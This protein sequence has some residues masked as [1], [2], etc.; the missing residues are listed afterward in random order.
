MLGRLRS[1]NQQQ[2]SGR[3]NTL[4]SYRMQG[5]HSP[6]VRGLRKE[7]AIRAGAQVQHVGRIQITAVPHATAVLPEAGG[8]SCR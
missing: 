8:R 1:S 2:S 4:S 5:L 7:Y 3:D 6:L